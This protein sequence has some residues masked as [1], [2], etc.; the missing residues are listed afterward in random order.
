MKIGMLQNNKKLKTIAVVRTGY[1]MAQVHINIG[2]EDKA[3][4]RLNQ[5]FLGP[6]QHTA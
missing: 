4:K 2:N 6:I 5:A 3:L 1:N